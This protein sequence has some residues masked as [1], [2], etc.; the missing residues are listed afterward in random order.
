MIQKEKVIVITHEDN[1]EEALEAVKN[2]AWKNAVEVLAVSPKSP[3]EESIESIKSRIHAS[4]KPYILVALAAGAVL[5]DYETKL[6]NALNDPEVQKL[7][8]DIEEVNKKFEVRKLPRVLDWVDTKKLMD[9]TPFYDRFL[10][11]GKRSNNNSWW[12]KSQFQKK[13]TRWKKV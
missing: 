9:N 2:T 1:L 8:K 6:A 11:K 3:E 7:A 13:V 4:E 12:N 10:K 5:P